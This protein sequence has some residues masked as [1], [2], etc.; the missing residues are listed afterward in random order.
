MTGKYDGLYYVDNGVLQVYTCIGQP[1]EKKLLRDISY[2]ELP[3]WEYDYACSEDE[4]EY[5]IESFTADFVKR[6]PSFD[7]DEGWLNQDQRVILSNKLFY[8]CLEDNEWSIAVELVA[9]EDGEPSI[10]GLQASLSQKYLNGIRGALFLQFEH[11]YIR[12]SAWTS[13]R[14]ENPNGKEAERVSA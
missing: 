13:G 3:L 5:F 6:F 11:L 8:V 1:E 12:T 10:H 7:V 2:G 14:I 9:K 4:Y